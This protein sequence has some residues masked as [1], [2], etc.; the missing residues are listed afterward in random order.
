MTNSAAETDI[1]LPEGWERRAADVRH[2]SAIAEYEREI[3]ANTAIIVS[4]REHVEEADYELRLTT[5]DSEQRTIQHGHSVVTFETVE[6]AFETTEEFLVHLDEREA[7]GSI[8]SE[9]L[10]PREVGD[11]IGEFIGDESDRWIDRLADRL[12]P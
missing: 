9:E 8:S 4:V 3:G 10:T 1:S 6:A 11:A 7:T 2:S 5:V 12:L